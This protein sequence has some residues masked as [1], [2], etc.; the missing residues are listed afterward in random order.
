MDDSK[1]G[2]LSPHSE[3]SPDEGVPTAEADDDDDEPRSEMKVGCVSVFVVW[4]SITLAGVFSSC[5]ELREGYFD[6]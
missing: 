6:N 5:S 3:E 4:S 2:R 1:D